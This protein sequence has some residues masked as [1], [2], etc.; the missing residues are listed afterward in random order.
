[1]FSRTRSDCEESFETTTLKR[2]Q[3]K[4]ALG[5]DPGVET[6]SRQENA[7]N[8][9]S[10]ARFDSIETE[11]A[12]ARLGMEELE[13]L[14]CAFGADAGNLAEIGDRRPLDL[15]QGSEVVQ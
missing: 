10:R 1:M 8:Q 15:L 6:G 14:A 3:A 5:L 12:L 7:S 13:N 4:H 9:E 2:F 11:K